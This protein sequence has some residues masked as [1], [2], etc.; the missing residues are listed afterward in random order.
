M[1]LTIENSHHVSP[2]GTLKPSQWDEMG[3]G[4]AATPTPQAAVSK[5]ILLKN[6]L[7]LHPLHPQ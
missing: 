4:Q 2:P 6:S 5:E 3:G 7:P 1:S